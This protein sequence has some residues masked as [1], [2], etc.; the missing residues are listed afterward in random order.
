[1]PSFELNTIDLL[2][3]PVIFGYFL[4]NIALLYLPVKKFLKNSKQILQYLIPIAFSVQIIFGYIFYTFE[5]TK[6]YYPIYI[7][8][9]GA[10]NI[11][12]LRISEPPNFNKLWKKLKP[13]VTIQNV[14]LMA[15]I[16][17]AVFYSRFYDSMNTLAPGN[18]D[19]YNHVQF[20]KSIDTVGYI[21]ST[22]YAPGFHIL[23][24]PLVR[25]MPMTSIYR[26]VGP[27]LGVILTLS[28][29]LLV[30][31][32]LKHR[33]SLFILAGL[34]LLPVFNQLSLQLI[35]FF[36]SSLTFMYLVALMVIMATMDKFDRK[37]LVLFGLFCLGLS[38]SV[39][40]FYVSLLPAMG[41]LIVFD[42]L[43]QKGEN[44]KNYLVLASILFL[45]LAVSYGH[46][47]LQTS[48][49]S[50][51]AYFPI[52]PTVFVSDASKKLGENEILIGDNHKECEQS[53]SV[54]C[55]WSRKL[56]TQSN[57]LIANFAPLINSGIDVI[58][59]IQIRPAGDLL[60]IGAYIWIVCA[61][62]LLFVARKLKLPMLFV[63]ASFSIV[64]GISA[65]TG[66]FEL[67]LYKGRS[68]WYLLLLCVLGTI[69]VYDHFSHLLRKAVPVVIVGLALGG[70]VVPPVFYRPYYT[71]H[72]AELRELG[73]KESRFLLVS[74]TKEDSLV[75]G[76][77]HY[78]PLNEEM[79]FGTDF[80][81]SKGTYVVLNLDMVDIDPVMSQLGSVY[82]YNFERFNANLIK[83]EVAQQEM[84][85]VL[86]EKYRC[87]SD[88]I[89]WRGEHTVLCKI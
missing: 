70:L 43:L 84:N 9:L 60:S 38:F 85:Q 21:S 81:L 28:I 22:F 2:S 3:I 25:L 26:F 82:D 36:S 42:L 12:L 45:G 65:Q 40:Y 18:N 75:I 44:F 69:F 20:L 5:L 52:I 14:F 19:T 34:M 66:M 46:V 32:K 31:P 71:E 47:L 79:V 50:N 88:N 39:P 57:Q 37:L 76:G 56:G 61:I 59:I 74:P 53:S 35:S 16:A 7:L 68:G 49:H 10:I 54:I 72:L 24:Y 51:E 13:R 62:V 48:V 1:M 80:N 23:V 15:V 83:R 33:K 6:S 27:A 87:L 30:A 67:S 77:T 64:L 78:I 8:I 41:L 55:V 17:L 58:K 89:V 11:Y 4:F 73:L 29:L 63:V 86:E